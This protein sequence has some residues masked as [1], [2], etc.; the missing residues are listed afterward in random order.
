MYISVPPS[1][2]C[3]E[4]VRDQVR[5]FPVGIIAEPIFHMFIH[6][7]GFTNYFFFFFQKNNLAFLVFFWVHSYGCLYIKRMKADA[8]SKCQ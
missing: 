6:H 7:T 8:I 4:C 3:D 1:L 5:R 2:G